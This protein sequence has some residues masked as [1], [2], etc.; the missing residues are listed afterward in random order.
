ML[1]LNAESWTTIRRKSPA[2]GAIDNHM[3]CA[4]SVLPLWS[5]RTCAGDPGGAGAAEAVFPGR[6]AR[7]PG[8]AARHDARAR[9]SRVCRPDKDAAILIADLPAAGLRADRQRR[10]TRRPEEAGRH[11]REARADRSSASAK[12]FCSLGRQVADKNAL[13]K[14]LL[15]ATARRPDRADHRSGARSGQRTIRMRAL[16][17]ALATLAVRAKVPKTSELSLLPFSVGELGRIPRR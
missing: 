13:R 4:A 11:R 10:S 7:R 17:A 6:L 3:L 9:P 16:R 15:V 1:K 14:W 8:T 2:L 12:A 5:F